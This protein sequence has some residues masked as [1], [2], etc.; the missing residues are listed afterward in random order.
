M[1]KQLRQNGYAPRRHIIDNECS[2]DI[3]QALTKYNVDF[4]RV[5]PHI[6]RRN[7]AERAIQ[8]LE[9]HFI[10]CLA[11]CDPTIP[12]SKWDRLISQS[13]INLNFLSSSRR[14]PHLS[15]Y[16]CLF[17]HFDYNKTP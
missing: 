14:K 12:F 8:T 5:S 10:S 4:Q 7:A 17:G 16:T 11:T 3:K 1:G 6:H 9:A 15:T 2:N 13:N